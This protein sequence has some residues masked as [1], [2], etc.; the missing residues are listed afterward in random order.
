[1]HTFRYCSGS[2]DV[3]TCTTISVRR[4][5]ARLSSGAR[6]RGRSLKVVLTMLIPRSSTLPR[7]LA[8]RAA[9][10]SVTNIHTQ[11]ILSEVLS[12]THFLVN[13]Y[14]LTS[15][16]FFF[17]SLSISFEVSLMLIFLGTVFFECGVSPS[18]R[19]SS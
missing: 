3:V 9:D 15:G 6:E 8:A 1:M 5:A 17:N 2:D 16:I 19:V 14:K 12:S 10:V 13:E 11:Q 18:S 7:L 4:K